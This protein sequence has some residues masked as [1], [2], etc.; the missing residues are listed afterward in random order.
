LLVRE[1]SVLFQG[2]DWDV[3]GGGGRRWLRWEGKH[4]GKGERGK[5]KEEEGESGG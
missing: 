3:E 4:E 2:R 1:C 5:G